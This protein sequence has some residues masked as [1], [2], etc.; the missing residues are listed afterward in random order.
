MMKQQYSIINRLYMLVAAAAT[1]T[2]ATAAWAAPAHQVAAPLAGHVPAG[3][4]F[5]AGWAGRPQNWPGYKSSRLAGILKHSHIADFFNQ[6]IPAIIAARAN[7]NPDTMKN[8]RNIRKI[9]MLLFNHP[10]AIYV[11]PVNKTH[12]KTLSMAMIIKAGADRN[13]ILTELK[14]FQPQHPYSQKSK[15]QLTRIGS[16]GPYVYE[17]VN[18]TPAM[19]RALRGQGRTLN[20]D[21]Y[22]QTALATSVAHPALGV[23]LNFGLASGDEKLLAAYAKSNPQAAKLLKHLNVDNQP[24][25]YKTYS[26]T[27]GFTSGQWRQDNFLAYKNPPAH[28]GH[29]TTLL[30]LVPANALTAAVFHLNLTAVTNILLA[31]AKAGGQK[32]QINQALVTVNQMTGVD[33]QQDLIHALGSRWLMYELPSHGLPAFNGY[34]LANRLT[35]PNRL[36]QALAVLM[37][38]AVMGG[39]AMIKQRGMNG[40]T[41]SMNAVQMGNVTINEVGTSAALLCYAIDNNNFFITLNLNTMR[42]AISQESAKT[43][44]LDNPAFQRVIK[45]LGNP[46]SPATVSFTDSPRL[47][48]AGYQL[49]T[50]EMSMPLT[51]EG[52]ELPVTLTHIAPPLKDLTAAI[53]P[54]GS[55]SW[56]DR[57]GWHER[58]I[59]AFPLAGI[60]TAQSP[61]HYLGFFTSALTAKSAK[62]HTSAATGTTAPAPAT[63]GQ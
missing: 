13:K 44:V 24:Q 35:H 42:A 60:F 52:I 28:P 11:L 5:Y 40:D 7:G 8:A 6:D 3:V 59:S 4:A 9:A 38:V 55:L 1:V 36:M 16:A 27:A 58:S 34:V 14:P 20:S 12:P 48:S 51:M 29:A 46:A 26:M 30:K 50:Q 32:R 63:T 37:P 17:V 23:Y 18:F 21:P 61:S 15:S 41:L 47:L 45:Q 22:F 57:A 31:A 43:S 49:L 56:F 10:F 54:S 19:L 2:G 62:P 33:L 39:N 25:P 53:E